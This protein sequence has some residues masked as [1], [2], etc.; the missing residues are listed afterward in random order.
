MESSLQS[1]ESKLLALLR[2][3]HFASH[4][5]QRGLTHGTPTAIDVSLETCLFRTQHGRL[6]PRHPGEKGEVEMKRVEAVIVRSTIHGTLTTIDTFYADLPHAESSWRLMFHLSV[7][8]VGRELGET[9]TEHRL[10]LFRGSERLGTLAR[11]VG[12]CCGL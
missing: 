8:E 6:H 7:A 9:S 5:S 11:A 10:L 4:N 3:T 2:K 1:T 12:G